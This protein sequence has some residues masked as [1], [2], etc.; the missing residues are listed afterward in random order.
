LCAASLQ[1]VQTLY[2]EHAYPEVKKISETLLKKEPRSVELHLLAAKADLAMNQLR[3]AV[4][5]AK[6][7]ISIDRNNPD[8]Y[9]VIADALIADGKP[10]RA[11]R[12]RNIAQ[13]LRDKGPERHRIDI[14]LSLGGG[15]D[16]NVNSHP[17]TGQM[18]EYYM[19][20]PFLP[21]PLIPTKKRSAA[22]VQE[23][24]FGTHTYD[25]DANTPFSYKSQVMLFNKNV[26]NES[27]YNSLVLSLKTGPQWNM[28]DAKLWLPLKAG[29]MLYGNEHYSDTYA[30]EPAYSRTIFNAYILNVSAKAERTV[31]NDRT[32]RGYDFERYGGLVGLERSWNTQKLYVGYRYF[33]TAARFA[34]TSLTFADSEDH[35]LSLRYS[36]PLLPGFNANLQYHYDRKSFDDVTYTTST[37][38]RKDDLHIIKAEADYTLDKTSFIH[39]ALKYVNNN[40]NYLPLDYDRGDLMLTYNILF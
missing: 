28:G 29:T 30:F 24:V 37:E 15:Y 26:I 21:A 8:A 19:L 5:H 2:D 6:A 4:I 3:S 13:N 16:S 11:E 1:D 17:G 20:D 31:Y 40:S 7:A 36:L 33:N 12:F 25:A 10:K 22:Y 18:N 39:A 27:D 23:M 14:L 38:K 35:G 9:E 34:S 32:M